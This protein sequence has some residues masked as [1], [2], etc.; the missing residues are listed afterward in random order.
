MQFTK[1]IG[2]KSLRQ[3]VSGTIFGKVYPWEG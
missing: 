1:H 3:Q 2:L